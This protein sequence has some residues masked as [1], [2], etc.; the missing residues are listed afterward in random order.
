MHL[1]NTY[2]YQIEVEGSINEEIFNT[3]SPIQIEVENIQHSITLITVYTDQSGI[4]GL[5]RHL[6]RL[7]F[8]VIALNRKRKE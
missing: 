1:Q 2:I 7:G 3:A 5:L 6:H 4:I 8:V